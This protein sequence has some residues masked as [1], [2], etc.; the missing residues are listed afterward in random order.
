MINKGEL[1]TSEVKM[2]PTLIKVAK[3]FQKKLHH[4]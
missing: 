1:E 3:S 2:L 4:L